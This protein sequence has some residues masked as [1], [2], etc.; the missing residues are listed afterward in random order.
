MQWTCLSELCSADW[1]IITSPFNHYSTDYVKISVVVIYSDAALVRSI[2]PCYWASQ[3]RAPLIALLRIGQAAPLGFTKT[4][5]QTL[6]PRKFELMGLFA[7]RVSQQF[8]IER[9]E[10]VTAVFRAHDFR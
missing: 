8:Q 10:T 9:A 6:E 5:H 4:P 3:N 2:L 1:E 7:T